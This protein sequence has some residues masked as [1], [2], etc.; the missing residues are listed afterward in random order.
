MRAVIACNKAARHDKLIK[1]SIGFCLALLTIEHAED[2]CR[3]RPPDVADRHYAMIKRTRNMRMSAT[4]CDLTNIYAQDL[5]GVSDKSLT[6]PIDNERDR[7]LEELQELRAS[8]RLSKLR[9]LK[10]KSKLLLN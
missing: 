2:W 4:T 9:F 7:G 1:L 8:R 3:V 5:E 6:L 10:T